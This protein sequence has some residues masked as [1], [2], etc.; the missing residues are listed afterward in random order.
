MPR[1]KYTQEKGP[2]LNGILFV[3]WKELTIFYC[4][5][6]KKAQY[7]ESEYRNSNNIKLII[8][9]LAGR[10]AITTKYKLSWC[11]HNTEM[12]ETKTSQC[13]IKRAN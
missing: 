2:V 9:H 5:M 11:Q 1:T 8:S 13:K 4:D 7:K 10:I 12:E 6:H 3:A